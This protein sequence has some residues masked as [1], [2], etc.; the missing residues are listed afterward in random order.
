MKV[1][2]LLTIFLLSFSVFSFGEDTSSAGEKG[3][4]IN[5]TNISILEFIKF[6]SKVAEVNFVFDEEALDF[7]VSFISGKPVAQ[8]YILGI[9]VELLEQN[10][11]GV[12][13]Y[14]GYFVLKKQRDAKNNL[15][16]SSDDK[17]LFSR[18]R[19]SNDDLFNIYKVKYHQGS[20]ILQAIKKSSK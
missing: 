15:V 6:V 3:Y 4:T 20:E 12:E 14:D 7:T 10:G 1:L 19:R 2:R 18:A 8:A 13:K 11:L 5:F 9:L 16:A 17:F